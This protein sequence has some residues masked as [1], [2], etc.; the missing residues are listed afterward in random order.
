MGKRKLEIYIRFVYSTNFRLWNDNIFLLRQITSSF[1]QWLRTSCLH[2]PSMT[3]VAADVVH[4]TDI[5]T[6]NIN[7]LH[8]WANIEFGAAQTEGTQHT[9]TSKTR[10]AP[11]LFN[12]NDC[13]RPVVSHNSPTVQ[14]YPLH[15]LARGTLASELDHYLREKSETL[16]IFKW[17]HF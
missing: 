2:P 16:E 5:N 13:C 7:S 8:P 10:R 3:A 4:S 9:Y 11:N 1:S 12:S 6:L 14:N 15:C 17:A